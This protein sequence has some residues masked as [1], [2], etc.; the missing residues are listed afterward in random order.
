MAISC[1]SIFSLAKPS[2]ILFVNPSKSNFG[3]SDFE[4]EDTFSISLIVS[5]FER[6]NNCFLMNNLSN[7]D[8]GRFQVAGYWSVNA[9]MISSHNDELAQPGLSLKQSLANLDTCLRVMQSTYLF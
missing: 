4:T 7:M 3:F 6:E 1:Q 5:L 2:L 9:P 8:N